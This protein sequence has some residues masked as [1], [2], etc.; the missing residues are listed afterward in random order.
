MISH[1]APSDIRASVTNCRAGLANNVSCTTPPSEAECLQMFTD[2]ASL[3]MG[4][5]WLLGL[6]VAAAAET[7]N[8]AALESFLVSNN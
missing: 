4:E 5:Q 3:M 6:N 8:L 1:A 2:V 7:D